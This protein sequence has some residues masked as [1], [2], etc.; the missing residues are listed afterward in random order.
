[1]IGPIGGFVC[2]C[3]GLDRD[4]P[5]ATVLS[6][7]RIQ[8][9][10]VIG[11]TPWQKV[12]SRSVGMRRVAVRLRRAASTAVLTVKESA[13]LL[14]SIAIAGMRVVPATFSL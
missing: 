8:V 3:C 10:E 11:G 9:T 4:K 13:I 5:V 14:N 7:S 1:V 2:S 6:Y 12:I